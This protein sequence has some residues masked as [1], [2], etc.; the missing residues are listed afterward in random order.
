MVSFFPKPY[1][2][3]ILYSVLARYHIRSGNTNAKD[4]SRDLFNSSTA[5]ATADLPSHLDSLINN[6]PFLSKHTVESLIQKHTLYPFYAVFLPPERADSVMESM[7]SENG[8][9][10]HS[11]AGILGHSINTPR[12]FRFCPVCL[13]KELQEYGEAYWH[14]LHQIPGVFICSQHGVP[15]EDSLVPIQNFNNQEY[16]AA[17]SQNCPFHEQRKTYSNDTLKKLLTLSRD[18]GWLLNSH[19]SS[20]TR[21]Y[22]RKQYMAL[23]IENGLATA[24]GRIYRKDLLDRFLFFY[25]HEFLEILDSTVSYEEE[26]NWLFD[27]A[28]KNERSFHPVRHLLMIRFLATSIATF[29]STDYE[30][31]P[32]GKAPWLCLNPAAEHYLKPVVT[33]LVIRQGYHTKKPVGE[34][35]C[36]CGFVYCRTGPDKTESDKYRI[37]KVKAR[38]QLWQEKL[39]EL[40]EVEKLNIYNIAKQL[41]VDRSTVKRQAAQ[42]SL[43]IPRQSLYHNESAESQQRLEG[44]KD[45]PENLQLKH[46]S[47]WKALQQQY[48]GVSQT[49]LRHYAPGTYTWLY[50]HD[51]EW[52]DENLPV[53]RVLP[54][55]PQRIDWHERDKQV[56]EQVKA[57]VQQLLKAEKPIRITIT[58]IGKMIDQQVLLRQ[59]H[60]NKIP[61]TKQYLESVLEEV[62]DYQIRRI[63]WA[64]EQLESQG[65]EVKGWKI[66]EIAGLTADCLEK[67]KVKAALEDELYRQ[68][69]AIA[70]LK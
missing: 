40:V 50:R 55:R 6:L 56:L 4:T 59:K 63:K 37:G 5:T 53:L 41:G 10:I 67:E 31:K 11:R 18:I 24:K 39:I 64:V 12:Y 36:S 14:R 60:L 38:G 23:L 61:L 70:S 32:F 57:A 68:S 54:T 29:F 16:C 28:R 49:T 20:R 43:Y 44:N 9:N 17:N 26:Q 58:R 47:H 48:R 3:E 25:G 30:Y 45:C 35:S 27:I 46:R 13:E 21:E 66:V 52:L 7:K 2:D 65:Q 22:F 19:L 62:E 1:P 15:L 51:K 8:G 33:K 34:F 69:T 42:L